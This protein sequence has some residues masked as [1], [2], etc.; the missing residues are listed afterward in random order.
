M[1][2]IINGQSVQFPTSLS[3]IT[4]KQKIDFQEQHGNTLAEMAKSISDMPDSLEKELE[5]AQFHY[6][7][8]FRTMSFFS[9]FSIEELKASEFIDKMSGIH[10]A[11]IDALLMQE[12]ELP[13]EQEF[14]W[15]GEIWTLASPEL[16]NGDKL[17]FG[18]FID[19]KQIIKTM[20]D[21]GKNRWE[22]LIPL[23]AI[24]LRKQNEAYEESFLYENSERLKLMEELPLDIAL[25]VGFFLTSSIHMLANTFQ[26]SLSQELK[27]PESTP[28]NTLKLG[29]G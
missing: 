5:M 23:A 10:F 14:T 13:F 28:Q 29:D 25:Q 15:K 18:E 19:S 8:M 22:C 16:K 3:E 9:G 17:T 27:M 26:Y 21:L 20:I 24:F 1:E 6:E 11:A 12:Q 2:L 4:L 7:Q